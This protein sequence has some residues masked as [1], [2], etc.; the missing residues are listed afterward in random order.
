ME[1]HISRAGA[2]G[3]LLP[4]RL[5]ALPGLPHRDLRGL[6]RV[7]VVRRQ[8]PG[9]GLRSGRRIRRHVTAESQSEVSPKQS[10]DQLKF[11]INHPMNTP[12]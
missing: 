12:A 8:I 7:R 3:G 4:A 2:G 6:E 9:S 1:M 10:N 11:P 5:L